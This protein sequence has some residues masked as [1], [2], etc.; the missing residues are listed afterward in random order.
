M[1]GQISMKTKPAGEEWDLD[2]VISVAGWGVDAVTGVEY[3]IVRNSWGTYMGDN[4]WHR[5]G[6]VGQNPL[7]I[8]TEC[9]W[10]VPNLPGGDVLAKDYGPDYNNHD[11][12]SS[13]VP[14]PP[15]PSRK[16]VS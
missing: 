5:V 3:W 4:G 6:P 16:Q 10:A 14:K 11:F 2:H 15:A 8:E 13:D 1:G 7:G 12:P 9:T